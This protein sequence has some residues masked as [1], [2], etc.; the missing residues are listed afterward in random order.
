MPYQ[1]E[2]AIM[3]IIY[4]NCQYSKTKAHNIFI[5]SLNLAVEVRVQDQKILI[6]KLMNIESFTNASLVEHRGD[7]VV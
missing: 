7:I 4:E 5:N 1:E 6:D 3:Q 2:E